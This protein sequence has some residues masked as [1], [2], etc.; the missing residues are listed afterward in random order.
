MAIAVSRDIYRCAA[1]DRM[2]ASINAIAIRG[3]VAIRAFRKKKRRPSASLILQFET[4]LGDGRL[5]LSYNIKLAG[6]RRSRDYL[7]AEMC[8]QCTT[9]EWLD[10]KD[11]HALVTL[12]GPLFAN[13]P[14]RDASVSGE[15]A[16]HHHAGVPH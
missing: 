3:G 13:V 11:G 12:I 10:R 15:S 14:P 5:P 1:A 16:M 6:L 2:I 7:H 4:S 8:A 9:Q